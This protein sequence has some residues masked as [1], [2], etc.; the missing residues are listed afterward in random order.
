MAALLTSYSLQRGSLAGRPAWHNA[1]KRESSSRTPRGSGLFTHGQEQCN[2]PLR[3][4]LDEKR[5]FDVQA[6][7]RRAS[8]RIAPAPFR[9]TLPGQTAFIRSRRVLFPNSEFG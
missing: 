9:A 8:I 1:Q 3:Q 7:Q 6:L 5:A 4:V 2:L